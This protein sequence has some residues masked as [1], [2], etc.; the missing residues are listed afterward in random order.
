MHIYMILCSRLVVSTRRSL[1]TKQDPHHEE[2]LCEE[3]L[4]LPAARINR[5]LLEYVYLAVSRPSGAL[6]RAIVELCGRSFNT[7]VQ[8]GAYNVQAESRFC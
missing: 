4:Q 8:V 3:L 5:Y 7:A 1:F 6:E 2:Q